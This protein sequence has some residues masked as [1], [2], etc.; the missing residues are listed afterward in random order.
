MS[1]IV[2]DGYTLNPGDLTWAPFEALGELV[3][4]DRSSPSET[5][6]RA[7]KA[8]VVLTNKALLGAEALAALPGLR[9]I[10]VLA[11]GYNVVDVEAAARRGIPVTNVPEYST[12]SVAQFVFALLLEL[13][14]QVGKHSDAVLREQKWVKCQDFSFT[15]S[16]LVELHGK[17]MGIVGFGK[18][19]RQTGA[20]ARAFGM[21]V[22]AHSRTRDKDPGYPFEWADIGTLFEQSDVVSLH[23]PLTPETKGLLNAAL[24]KRMKKTALVINTSRGPVVNEADLA[25]ALKAGV[26][27]GAGVDVL[28]TEPP[29]ADNPLLDAPNIVI[30]P[31]IAWATRAARERLMQTA[32]DNVAAW[33]NGKPVNVVNGV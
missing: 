8:E 26:I 23:C 29:G 2:L 12:A 18:T 19:G 14:H 31:H 4:Y 10:G 1:L 13:C 17:T 32:A 16:P 22:L 28:S 27:A 7:A 24:L 30:T 15:L 33:M 11:T 20:L 3:V 21:R 5:I 25:D 6:R 9:Y